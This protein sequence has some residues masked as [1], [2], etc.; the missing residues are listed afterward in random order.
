M[1]VV[2][3]TDGHQRKQVPRLNNRKEFMWTKFV[4][5]AGRDVPLT[6]GAGT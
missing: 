1:D 4:V 3:E 2:P 5:P 6:G